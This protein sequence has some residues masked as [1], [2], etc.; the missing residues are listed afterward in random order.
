MK[1]AYK[2]RIY[3][4]LPHLSFRSLTEDSFLRA[5]RRSSACFDRG[6]RCAVGGWR[7]S[8]FVARFRHRGSQTPSTLCHQDC[9]IQLSGSFDNTHTAD[10]GV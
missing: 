6:N 1:S 9:A 8:D 4:A 3:A 7:G 10:R 5:L 2:L